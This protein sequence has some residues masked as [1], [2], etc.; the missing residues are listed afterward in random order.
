ME[1]WTDLASI[2]GSKTQPVFPGLAED[3][4]AQTVDIEPDELGKLSIDVSEDVNGTDGLDA[5]FG[6][7][8]RPFSPIYG[9]EV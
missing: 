3:S 4:Q 7:F 6:Y 5:R 2:A 9:G 8:G 1:A